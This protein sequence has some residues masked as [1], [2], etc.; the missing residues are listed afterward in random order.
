M[1]GMTHHTDSIADHY[2]VVVVG[3]RAAGASTAML[4]AR[5]GLSVLA[6]DRGEYGSDTLS[7][8][9]L[10][11]PGVLQLSRWGLLDTIRSAGT[12]V[13]SRVVFHYG[14]EEVAIDVPARGDV[15]GLY[16]PRRTLLDATLVDAAV[17]AGADVRHGVTLVTVT[18]DDTG[19]VDGV[20]LDIGGRRQR[21]GARMVVGADGMRSRVARQVGA[22]TLHAETTGSTFIF[23]YFAGLPDD[24]IVNYY[25]SEGAV[26]MIPT[27]DGLSCVWVG[28]PVSRFD[29]VAKGRLAEAHAAGIATIPEFA[30]IHGATPV[31]GYKSF[32]GIPGFLRQAWGPGWAL[33]GDAGYFKDPVSAHGITDAFIGAELLADALADVF[34]GR[35]SEADALGHF[36]TVRDGMAAEMMPPVRSVASFPG[37]MDV[38]KAGFRDMSR[39]MRHETA[40]I[41][42]TF[43]ALASV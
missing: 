6:I 34:Q 38:V 26:A 12:P 13:T 25:D 37:D 39:A 35:A 20:E 30:A 15:D 42:S 11:G 32:P 4:L 43:G 2:D 41:E 18:S 22:E 27:N 14:S 33:V 31:G 1:V 16:S 17:E 8:H 24:A 21:V 7:T 19:R 3:A 9:S 10:A 29:R 36:Q 23:A 40:F 5:R 28:M